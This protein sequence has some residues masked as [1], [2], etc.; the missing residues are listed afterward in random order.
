M[1]SARLTPAPDV[2]PDPPPATATAQ[3]SVVLIAYDDVRNVRRAVASALHQGPA[4]AEVVAVDDAS[5]DGT[6]AVL[7]ALARTEPRLRVLHRTVNSGGCGTPRNEGLRAAT[8]RYVMFLD[9]DDVLPPGAVDTLLTAALRAG[10]PVAAGACVRRELPSL[11]EVRWQP[12]LYTRRRTLR[13]PEARP[14]LVRD[15]LCVNKLYDR[16]FLTGHD[17]RFPEGRY[18]YE[19]FVFTARVLAAAPRIALVPETVYVWQVR[20]DAARPSLSLDRDAVTNWQ[21]RLRAHRACVDILREAGRTRLAH[22]ARTKFLDHD[23]RMYA[24]E[25]PARDERHRREWWRLTRAHLA[26]FE[27]AELAAARAPARWV[28]RVVLACDTPV[29]LERLAELAA[30]PA[31][32]LPPYAQ[33]AGRAV[34]SAELPGVELD[35][36]LTKPV[37]RLPVTVEAEP[38]LG[39]RAEL[40][41]H[42]H[43]LYGRLAG[44]GPVGVDLALRRQSAHRS[45]P[46]HTAA[47]SP[48]P[49]GGWSA[50]VRLDLAALAATAPRGRPQ[51]WA[52]AATVRCA[53]G[54]RVRVALR[55]AG[56]G[57]RRTLVVTRR[58]L[59]LCRPYRTTGGALSLRVA[60]GATGAAGIAVRRA[61]RAV[62]GALARRR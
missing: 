53:D 13:S 48:A 45:G 51:S 16:R 62:S 26:G 25:L 40:R 56:P 29:D 6:G 58:G 38:V 21:A 8:G 32:L 22:A 20:R 43:D 2:H 12:E 17:V 28:A 27:A 50:R 18:V 30:R 52:L 55:P 39:R 9:S 46:V 57:L 5:R 47:L 60:R 23:L 61:R 35:G 24:V 1:S 44:A 49:G 11:R 19:D 14:R 15:T 7:D 54:S 34:W 42:V 36:I 10:A 31:R 41:L 37:T 4:V 59:L 33:A 3:V